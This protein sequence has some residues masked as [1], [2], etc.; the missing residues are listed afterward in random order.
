MKA[1]D[2]FDPDRG[3]RFSTYAVW[4][5][6]AEV[7]DFIRANNSV[8]RQPILAWIRPP[9]TGSLLKRWAW[10]CER[11]H[12]CLNRSRAQIVH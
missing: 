6:R 9:W 2:R 1:A 4:W 3:F 10:I 12:L 8:I 11:P 5:A 7:Q